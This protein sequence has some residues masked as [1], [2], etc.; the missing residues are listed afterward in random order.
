MRDI[1]RTVTSLDRPVGDEGDAAAGRPAAG[2][3]AGARGGGRARAARRRPC[4]RSSSE[5]PDARAHGHPDALRARRRP[6]SGVDPRGRAPAGDAPRGR[7]AARAARARGARACGAR[8]PLCADAASRLGGGAVGRQGGRA[9]A[10]QAEALREVRHLEQA[11]HRAVR[12]HH[13]ESGAASSSCAAALR[14]VPS[15]VESM[16]VTSLRSS[17]SRPPGLADGEG[18]DGR[19]ARRGGDVELAG[20]DDEVASLDGVVIDLVVHGRSVNTQRDG[21]SCRDDRIRFQ[22]P[23][24]GSAVRQ[25]DSATPASPLSRAGVSSSKAAKKPPTTSSSS[26]MPSAQN[27]I[28]W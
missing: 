20:G 17:T 23:A 1:A 9:R 19:E 22:V 27:S 14:I 11:A 21:F 3:R 10:V 18:E 6:R 15:A 25:A 4:A 8:W 16:N 24:Q 26:P 5:L 2:R 7:P 28:G 12:R 13:G